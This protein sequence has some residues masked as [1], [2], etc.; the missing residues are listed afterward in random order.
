MKR[1]LSYSIILLFWIAVLQLC[2]PIYADYF[3]DTSG[4]IKRK[5][6]TG[7]SDT[8]TD[9]NDVA[10]ETHNNLWAS[11]VSPYIVTNLEIYNNQLQVESNG[12]S[13]GARYTGSTSDICQITLKAQTTGYVYRNVGVRMSDSTSGYSLRLTQISG[14]N[15]TYLQVFK[16]TSPLG[17]L[18]T[19]G[20]WSTSADHVVRIVVSGT[21]TVTIEGYVDGDKVGTNIQ[22]SSS[23]L[24]SGNPGIWM[25]EIAQTGSY[26]DDWQD[27]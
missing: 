16:G 18:S 7:N 8:F 21:S 20:N 22:D 27:F 26:F 13:A 17:N 25:L 23:P 10:L 5:A 1:I 9:S 24:G 2:F 12:R 15:F 14:G 11:T 4:I 3:E 6:P 19:T